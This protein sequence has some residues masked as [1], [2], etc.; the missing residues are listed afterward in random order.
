METT[1]NQ[2]VKLTQ[3]QQDLL[4]GVCNFYGFRQYIFFVLTKKSLIKALD[5]IIGELE[6]KLLNSDLRYHSVLATDIEALQML[7]AQI[8]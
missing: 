3:S 7:Y 5:A 1:E 8:V 6:F 2:S 4:T